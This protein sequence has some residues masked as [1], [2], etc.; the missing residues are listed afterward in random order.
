VAAFP[1]RAELAEDEV[2]AAVV[3]NPGASLSEAE[4][5]DFCDRNMA[6]FMVPRFVEFMAALPKTMTE[7][8]EK[9][10]LVS[11]AQERLASIWDRDKV[12][13]VLRR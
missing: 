11:R 4:L 10:T 7:K 1:V 8:V 12:G 5:I 2:M 6:Y 13:I 3:L 9:F